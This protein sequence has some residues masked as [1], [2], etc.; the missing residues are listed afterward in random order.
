M[1]SM[2]RASFVYLNPTSC[3]MSSASK[4][5]EGDEAYN[6]DCSITAYG[7]VATELTIP[8][9]SCGFVSFSKA[10]EAALQFHLAI[11]VVPL[12]R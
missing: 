4:L 10:H 3:L 7:S 6:N 2:Y 9:C 12:S 5:G 8:T 1:L 11:S